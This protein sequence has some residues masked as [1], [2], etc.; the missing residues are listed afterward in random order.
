MNLGLFES[1]CWHKALAIF[2]SGCFFTLGVGLIVSWLRGRRRKHDGSLRGL[3]RRGIPW[4]QERS[5]MSRKKA[6]T[7][8]RCHG[9]M[10]ADLE[11]HIRVVHGGGDP[12]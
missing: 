3:D 9:K 4:R 1:I 2:L 6:G 8:H 11:E 7:C 5:E 10:F 12:K